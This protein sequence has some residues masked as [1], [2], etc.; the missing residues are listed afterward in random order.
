MDLADE[1]LFFE[2]ELFSLELDDLEFLFV[3]SRQVCELQLPLSEGIGLELVLLIDGH[4]LLEFSLLAGQV[5][6][7]APSLAHKLPVF[8]FSLVQHDPLILLSFDDLSEVGIQT[9]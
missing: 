5:R 1:L 3:F 7:H 4:Q 2:G 9:L 8:P 6:H